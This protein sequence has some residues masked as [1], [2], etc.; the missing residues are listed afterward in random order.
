[1]APSEPPSDESKVEVTPV[2][3]L[4]IAGTVTAVSTAVSAAMTYRR[5]EKALVED[6]I[7][8]TTRLRLL[9]MAARTFALSVA[10][11]TAFGALGFYALRANGFFSQQAAELPS[12][13]EA[14][15]LLRS[16]RAFFAE[17]TAAGGGGRGGR[18]SQAGADAEKE[19]AEVQQAAEPAGSSPR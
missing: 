7:D 19:A 17:L 18:G 12:A 4:L 13:A 9:P 15:R 1:M 16:P 5:G 6:G 8:P 11:T 3:V 2:D 10:M 14:A